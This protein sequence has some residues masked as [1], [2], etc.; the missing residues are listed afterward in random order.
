MHVLYILQVRLMHVLCI[1]AYACLMHLAR[2]GLC[3]SYASCKMRLMHVLCIL[4]V[5]LMRKYKRGELPDVQVSSQQ[6]SARLSLC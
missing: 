5:R 4:Q 2:C 6:P 3:M 1:S